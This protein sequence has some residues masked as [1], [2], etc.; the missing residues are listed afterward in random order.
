MLAALHG[1]EQALF[2]YAGKHFIHYGGGGLLGGAGTYELANYLAG[3]AA[4]YQY[5]A[6]FKGVCRGK[7]LIQGGGYLFAY[8]VH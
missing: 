3:G 6:F 1:K 7:K 8:S 4:Y 2:L 5:I